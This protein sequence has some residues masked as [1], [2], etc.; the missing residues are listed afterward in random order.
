ML[1]FAHVKGEVG[2][3]FA[4]FL[5]FC[6]FFSWGKCLHSSN[7]S[8]C[9]RIRYVDGFSLLKGL[10]EPGTICVGPTT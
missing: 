8:Q 1:I 6:F 5:G 4:V 10:I 9:F 2:F 7:Q 3:A